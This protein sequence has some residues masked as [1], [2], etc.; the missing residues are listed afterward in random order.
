MMDDVGR[1]G[2]QGQLVRGLWGYGSS[3]PSPSPG[4]TGWLVPTPTLASV[5]K[6]SPTSFSAAGLSG[7]LGPG[8][9]Q[10]QITQLLWGLDGGRESRASCQ[11]GLPWAYPKNI[12]LGSAKCS[13]ASIRLFSVHRSLQE[14]QSHTWALISG[15]EITTSG[16]G[17]WDRA[18]RS[19][20]Q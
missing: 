12:P 8:L 11:A 20:E 17:E 2:G 3:S 9:G 18:G 16:R 4:H 14:F 19:G 1:V 6:P 7:Q 15:R 5:H 13:G 10:K